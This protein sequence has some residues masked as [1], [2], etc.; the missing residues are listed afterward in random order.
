MG[1]IH[2]MYSETTITNNTNKQN[3]CSIAFYLQHQNNQKAKSTLFS[4]LTGQE[5]G[6]HFVL[7]TGASLNADPLQP[8]NLIF[9]TITT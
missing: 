9:Q 4:I 6:L 8:T 7:V 2:F 1:I 5:V 3:K